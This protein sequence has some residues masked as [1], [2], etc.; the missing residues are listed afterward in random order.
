MRSLR[1][2]H[3]TLL[4]LNFFFK[5]HGSPQVATRARDALGLLS[6]QFML[7]DDDDDFFFVCWSMVSF[8]PPSSILSLSVTPPCHR[9]VPGR[10]P[11]IAPSSCTVGRK[12]EHRLPKKDHATGN[13][14]C[15]SDGTPQSASTLPRSRAATA[16]TDGDPPQSLRTQRSQAE[17]KKEAFLDHLRQK[18]PHHA[19][20][21]LG[22]QEP[23]KDPLGS[24]RP[25]DSTLCEGAV[26]AGKMS[27]G[28]L[29]LTVPFARGSKARSSLPI[30]RSSSQAGESVG[31]L[32]LQYGDQTKQIGMPAE[33]SSEETLRA[34][35][36]A[37]FPQQLTMKKL[38]SPNMAIYIKDTRRNVYFDLEDIRNITSHSCLKVYHKDPSHVF[39]HPTGATNTEGRISKEVL[40][41]S[42]SPV[43]R[44]SSSSRGPLHGLQ[45][46]MSPPTVR[47]MPSSPSRVA[48]GGRRAQGSVART[49]A[50]NAALP[51]DRLTCAGRSSSLCTSSSAILERRDVKPDEDGGSCQ[52]VAL[53]VHGE[54]GARHPDLYRCA[55]PQDGGRGAFASSRCSGSLSRA[56]EM[57]DG[58]VGGIPGGL[59]QY[60]AS[61]K[62]LMGYGDIMERHAQSPHR[63][64]EV[65]M[66]EGQIIGGVGLISPERMSPI[67]R[68][69]RRESSGASVEMVNRS[70]GSASSSSTSSV[71]LD[72]PLRHPEMLIP[73]P[74][75]AFD[76]QSERLKAMEEQIASLAGLVHHALSVGGNIPRDKDL[77]SGSA[78]K[79]HQVLPEVPSAADEVIRS[80]SRA[81]QATTAESGLQRRLVQVK[82]SVSELRQQLNQL[83][84]LQ[85]AHQQTMKSMLRMAGQELLLLLNDRP[86]PSE[87]G[88]RGRRAEIDEERIDYL[89]A[90]EKILR[91]LSELEAYVSR[92]QGTPVSLPGQLRITLSDVEEGAVNLRRV[93]ETLAILK[94][95]FPELQ[96]KMRYVLRLE[97]D[98]VRFLKEE[99]HKMDC[100][101]KR[102]KALTEALGSLRRCVSESSSPTKGTQVESPKVSEADRGPPL[103]RN[104]RSSP[105]PQPRS[106][107]GGPQS[108]PS[109][110][111]AQPELSDAASASP[112]AA[113]RVKTTQAA[114]IQAHRRRSSAPEGTRGTHAASQVQSSGKP[115]AKPLENTQGE[116]PEGRRS[117]DA[118]SV[119]QPSS[120]R[121]KRSS[122]AGQHFR[123]VPQEA[124]ADPTDSVPH[125]D[126][127][128]PN[129]AHSDLASGDIRPR[130]RKPDT[131]PPPDPLPARPELPP[132][133]SPSAKRPPMEKP[134]RA[135]VEK[136]QSPDRSGQSPPARPRRCHAATVGLTAAAR[137][138]EPVST[139][140]KGEKEACGIPQAKPPRQPPEVKAK[141]KASGTT[142]ATASENADEEKE[143]NDTFP[144]EPPTSGACTRRTHT[145][146][147]HSF[148]SPEKTAKGQQEASPER[149]RQADKSG[150]KAAG[151][152]TR[153]VVALRPSQTQ[154]ALCHLKLGRQPRSCASF[155]TP[156][157]SDGLQSVS[158]SLLWSSPS[159]SSANASALS[160]PSCT[161]ESRQARPRPPPSSRSSG[162]K[163]SAGS[164]H[165]SS[166]LPRA[167]PPHK[168]LIPSLNLSRLLPSSSK[169]W[170]ASL[171]S[172]DPAANPSLVRRGSGSGGVPLAGA[173][174]AQLT[175]SSSSSS[176]SSSATSLSPA[177]SSSSPLSPSSSFHHPSS[178][179]RPA[180]PARRKKCSRTQRAVAPA[181][182]DTG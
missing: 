159:K 109:S 51:R 63:L 123:R 26:A 28:E 94:G 107:V 49:D 155:S 101:L 67:R 23:T 85:T 172:G 170:S 92:L 137:T 4:G 114:V 160:V 115:T 89:A 77:I 175:C 96:V 86:V 72:S 147:R 40:Y 98:A 153:S 47:S 33:I 144:K 68:S 84:H 138:G 130:P 146:F 116:S 106:S 58:G 87:E 88:P 29:L 102:V 181:P 112:A 54:G 24:P 148:G 43:H 71:F 18:Y 30:G 117:P 150:T 166:W 176:S 34:L 111:F 174:A 35:F 82:S 7:D 80:A 8:I 19:A 95:D 171:A 97:M 129:A 9:P 139:S 162:R 91:Q 48:Y 17:R 105:Q 46:S 128:D 103:T 76:A 121:A 1:R 131:E 140:S 25:P 62:P 11:S 145:G 55:S 6:L 74:R 179:P 64:Y 41:G 151:E 45:G 156:R 135:S 126:G 182:K 113:R 154:A 44:L 69:L 134:R 37:A 56:A 83:R 53:V 78:G 168:S 122:N 124:R 31:V 36:V 93:G 13:L 39:N 127:S 90:E 136:K 75:T 118:S 15:N 143:D 119:S 104:P 65:G 165:C 73:G 132:S 81:L 2:A 21:V 42:H 177:S 61:I 158:P 14:L 157:C 52:S 149:P 125:L 108:I 3:Q 173:A 20:I 152:S 178:G 66:N 16:G 110:A 163:N 180:A 79:S 100:M 10:A 12:T 32:Y 142:P 27:D 167:L 120:R 38:Q 59:P 133:T 141:A 57:G 169:V 22:Q 99:P 161:G 60:R 164:P 50:G 70:R 5:C